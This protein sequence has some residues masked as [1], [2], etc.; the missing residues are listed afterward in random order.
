MVHGGK[1]LNCKNIMLLTFCI[2]FTLSF[3]SCDYLNQ[4]IPFVI[5]NIEATLESD[6][7]EFSYSGVKFTFCNTSKKDISKITVCF[8]VYENEKGGNPFV[9]SNYIESTFE[10]MINSGDE[11]N[12]EVSLDEKIISPPKAPYYVDYFFVKSVHFTDNSYWADYLGLISF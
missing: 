4:E 2:L 11:K 8:T 5:K 12:F 10:G 9:T 1:M 7:N 3:S 6:E